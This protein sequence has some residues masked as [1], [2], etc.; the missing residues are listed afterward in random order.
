[1]KSFIA[2]IVVVLSAMLA[3]PARADQ[4]VVEIETKYGLARISQKPE[5]VVSLSYIGHDFLLALGIKPIALRYWYG[6]YPNGV[7][8]W[9]QAALGDATPVVLRGKID[10]ERIAAL[11][12]DLI[13]GL[14]SGMTKDEY[15]ILSQVAPTIAPQARHGDYNTPWRRMLLTLGTVTGTVEQARNLIAHHDQR[16]AAI[17]SAH[18]DWQGKTASVVWPAQLGAFKSN[19]I[20]AR[21]LEE[22]GLK[23]SDA[24]D[25]IGSAGSFYVNLS[26]EDLS[27][28]D[29]DALLWFG[30]DSAVPVIKGI[31][32][33]KTMNAEREGREIIAD[34]LLSSAISHSSP[35][36][37]EYALDRLVPLLEQALDGDPL[38]VVDSSKDAGLLQ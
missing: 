37:L 30:G 11:K 22:L 2:I 19:D 38:T 15:R 8:P 31:A 5:R 20:R 26:E 17:R 14:W 24:L 1:M 12:P 25:A 32:L 6:N 7:W 9:A 36:S 33:R 21:L 13:V 18:P 35:L 4:S 16:I 3:L 29:T 34:G 28:I 23:V 27:P 10:V